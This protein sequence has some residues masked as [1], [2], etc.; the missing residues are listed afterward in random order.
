MKTQA[1]VVVSS[2]DQGRADAQARA[3]AVSLNSA[4]FPPSFA[5]VITRCT[6]LHSN[7][8]VYGVFIRLSSMLPVAVFLVCTRLTVR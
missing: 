6:S 1:T 5:R 4:R 7:M 2:R 3:R 8:M